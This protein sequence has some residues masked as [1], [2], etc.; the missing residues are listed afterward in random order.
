MSTQR[1]IDP[2]TLKEFDC[3]VTQE[4][5]ITEYYA[6]LWVKSLPSQWVPVYGSPE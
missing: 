6:P 4:K 5:G 2:I 1:F 3:E